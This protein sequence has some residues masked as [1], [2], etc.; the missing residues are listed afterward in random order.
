MDV[1]PEARRRMRGKTRLISLEQPTVPSTNASTG[2]TQQAEGDHDDKRGRIDEPGSPVSAVAQDEVFTLSPVPFDSETRNDE[3]AVDVPLP[4]EPAEMSDENGQGWITEEAFFT[5]SPGARQVRQRKEV[6]MN[7]L[8]PAERREFLKSM[9]VEWQ[10]LL[11]NQGAKALSLEETAQARA[12]WLDRAMDTLW[13]RNQTTA[14]HRGA[15]R[16]HDSSLRVSQTLTSLTLSHILRHLPR[17]GFM[18]VLQSVCSHGHK[19]HGD[20]QQ[21]FNTG[22]SIKREQPLFVRMP[23]DRV[24]GESRDVWVQ[25]LKTVNG[26]DDGTRE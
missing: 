1:D 25:L 6:K 2:T 23:P 21:A 14:S 20:V 26:L 15:V 4:E 10:T 19:L 9:E 8:S 24:P 11:K 17:E 16:R 13:A 3:I 18:T 22:D 5:V 12:R 7:Q